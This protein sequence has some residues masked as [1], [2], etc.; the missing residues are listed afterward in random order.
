MPY[1]EKDVIKLRVLSW[2]I[3]LAPA[4]PQCNRKCPCKRE[5][6]GVSTQAEKKKRKARCGW[7]QR[8][9][10]DYHEREEGVCQKKRKVESER[11]DAVLLAVKMKEEATN[12]GMQQQM[13]EKA[14]KWITPLEPL[15]GVW[16][17]QHLDFSQRY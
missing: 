5:A 13:L 3:I 2:K 14:R 15:K 4:G 1:T 16:S 10:S 17:C 12:Q 6:E 7:K 11:G 8:T 9:R